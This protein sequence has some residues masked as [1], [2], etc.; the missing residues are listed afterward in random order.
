MYVRALGYLCIYFSFPQWNIDNF[1]TNES[2]INVFIIAKVKK[3]ERMKENN[4]NNNN[5]NNNKQLKNVIE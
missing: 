2:I 4:N 1:F 3:R 5:N